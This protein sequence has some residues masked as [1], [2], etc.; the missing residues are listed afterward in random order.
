MM[1]IDNGLVFLAIGPLVSIE[2]LWTRQ[3]KLNFYV[4]ILLP[5]Y[6]FEKS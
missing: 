3:I 2:W 4:F 5:S 1:Y 6:A